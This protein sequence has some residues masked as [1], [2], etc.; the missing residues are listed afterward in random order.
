MQKSEV[1]KLQWLIIESLFSSLKNGKVLIG[2]AGNIMKICGI[3]ADP[4]SM[5]KF[6]Q[7]AESMPYIPFR[8]RR[9]RVQEL[10]GHLYIYTIRLKENWVDHPSI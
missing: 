4:H 7:R 9:K 5:A 8:V 1:R 6:L 3:Q 10:S 2:N